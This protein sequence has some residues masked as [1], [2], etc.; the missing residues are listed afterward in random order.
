[1]DGW[2]DGGSKGKRKR[3]NDVIET[4][5][6]AFTG[7]VFSN[8]YGHE[9]QQQLF[10]NNIHLYF[11]PCIHQH[12]RRN[13]RHRHRHRCYLPRRRRRPHPPSRRPPPNDCSHRR[14]YCKL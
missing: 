3:R 5:L 9:R 2:M 4:H 1:M 11:I 10:H 6:S 8:K 13:C 7:P 12:T 14:H